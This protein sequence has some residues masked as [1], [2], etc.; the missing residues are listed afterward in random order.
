MSDFYADVFAELKTL[1]LATWTDVASTSFFTSIQALQQ[2]FVS[3]IGDG[4]LALP[5]S[6]SA[7]FAIMDAG[8]TSAYEDASLDSYDFNFPVGFYYLTL[9]SNVANDAQELIAAKLYDLSAA[10]ESRPPT[11][12]TCQWN[13]VP[14]SRDTSLPESL[15]TLN[16]QVQAGCLRYDPGLIVRQV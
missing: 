4:Q 5:G 6:V 11:L 12:T 13:G 15:A 2:N 8:A 9:K 1:V 14:G 16:V 7:P 10:I 3:E